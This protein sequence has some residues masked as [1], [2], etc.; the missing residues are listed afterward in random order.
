MNPTPVLPKIYSLG[1]KVGSAISNLF[2][3]SDQ[4]PWSQLPSASEIW[5]AVTGFPAFYKEWWWNLL[6]NDPVHVFIETTLLCAI[7]YFLL[8]RRSKD[9]RHKK[10]KLL[11]SQEEADL[12]AEWKANR[13]PLTPSSKTKFHQISEH[14]EYSDVDYTSGVTGIVVHKSN[15]RCMD[16][17]DTIVAEGTIK[18]VLNFATFDFLGMG[19]DT[20]CLQQ[21]PQNQST[22]SG[23]SSSTT[24]S[25]KSVQEEIHPVREASLHALD[26]YGC[27]SCGPRGFYGTVDVHLEL[28]QVVAEFCQTEGAILYSDGA[29]AVSSTIASFCKRGDLIVVDEGVYEPIRTGIQLSRANVQW[30]KHNDME[31]LRRVMTQIQE[32]DRKLGRKI[33]AQRRFVVVEGLYKNDGSVCRL[34][35]L[36]KL[37]HEFKYRLIL[38]E[39]FSF[40]ILGPT[41]RGILEMYGLRTMYDA[42]IVLV[43]LENAMGSIGGLT[44]GSAEVVDHQRLSGSGYCFSAS[45]PPFTATAAM[46]SLKLLKDRPDIT[47]HRLNENRAYL[48][49]KLK[50]LL[51]EKLEDLLLITSDEQS[52]IV[53]M[54]VAEI[55]ETAYLNEV[56]FLQEVVRESLAR[57]VAMVATGNAQPRAADPPPGIRMS[58]SASHTKDDIDKALDVLGEAV[59]VVMGRFHDEE[60]EKEDT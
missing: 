37:K 20:I 31:D 16:I 56:V 51:H 19:A 1:F 5:N 60:E 7:V 30:F 57:G 23:K 14:A 27:G 4:S 8:A 3:Q 9:W 42:E 47:L 26:R 41:G 54:Q 15:G 46:A 32:S 49:M 36:V 22:N 50:T 58:V 29:S 28:E 40:G 13:K 17:E 48:Y 44:V 43:G 59:D 21:D 55:P 52:P 25:P 18:T 33:N 6:Q 38:D 34:D 12:L 10:E 45:S 11:S 2:F 39:T 24:K 53:M 35:E